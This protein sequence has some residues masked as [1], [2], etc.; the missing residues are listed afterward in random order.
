M[1]NYRLCYDIHGTYTGLV[2]SRLPTT[3]RNWISAPSGRS[4]VNPSDRNAS[5]LPEELTDDVLV[6][7]KTRFLSPF[8][9]AVNLC[10]GG[11]ESFFPDQR[12]LM[13]TVLASLRSTITSASPF[14]P[15]SFQFS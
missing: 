6:F 4:T 15:S 1:Y 2:S 13:K 10:S 14:R 8:T 7:S 12:I 3:I 5:P 9:N 11:P